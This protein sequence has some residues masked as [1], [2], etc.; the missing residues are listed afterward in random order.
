MTGVDP[1]D[2]GISLGVETIRRVGVFVGLRKT[3]RITSILTMLYDY[4]VPAAAQWPCLLEGASCTV[5]P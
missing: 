1:A 2:D 5:V 3:Q 4:N